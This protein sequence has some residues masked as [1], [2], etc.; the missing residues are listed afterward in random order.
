MTVQQ[1]TKICQNCKKEFI[2]AP[3]DFGFYKKID[4]PAP[5]F[6]PQCRFQ[7]R[8]AYRN[9]RKLHL[10]A[11]AKSGKQ[12]FSLYPSEGGA[13]VY[14]EPEWWADD[15][16]PM[17]YGRDYDFSK[18]FF[19]QFYELSQ[20]VPRYA[21]DVMNVVNSDYSGNAQ[22]FKNCY[23]LF[24]SNNVEDSAYGNAVDYS[25]TCFD[26]SHINKGERCYENFWLTNCHRTFFSVQC[27]DCINVWFS[28][29]CTGCTDCFGC[30]NL[31][32]KQFHI[33]NKPY[34]KEEYAQKIKAMKIDTWTGLEK[35]A[36]EAHDFWLGFPNKYMQGVKNVNANGEYVT[37]SKNVQEGYL[38]REGEDLKYVQYLQIP[39]NKDCYDITVWGESNTL[40]YEN[41]VCGA[42]TF[43]VKFCAEC[44]PDVRDME[45]SMFC[46]SSESLFGCAGLRKKKYCILNKQYSKDEFISLREKII[47]HMN[48][49][50]YVD[51]KGRVYRYGEFFPIELSAIPYNHSIVQEHFPL[52]E[53]AVKEQGWFWLNPEAKEYDITMEAS[54]LP[55]TSKEADKSILKEIIRCS[56]CKRA[57]RIIEPELAFLQEEGIP[58][59]R[60]CVDCRHAKRIAWRNKSLLYERACDCQGSSSQNA[61][62]KNEAN[63]F[64]GQGVCPNKFKSA[65]APDRPD[66]VYCEKCYIEEVA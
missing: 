54:T 14:S 16:D 9:D 42:G 29:N 58:L 63:H 46:K 47:D 65:Y 41:S 36:K 57:Y 26:N 55:E 35:A 56:E 34:S 45:Y 19:K 59:P 60:L 25:H 33:F 27:A 4:V 21:L 66:I 43:N 2:I 44:W 12:I 51:K 52:E 30:V 7:R 17:Q 64:H 23:L 50:P 1:E 39:F 22:Y 32:N 28:K 3:E 24:N 53:N 13:T 18:P 10:I 20:Q 8:A 31:R 62:Y 40:A 6:C 11:S 38:V 48:D 49:M 15:W 37:N 61:K 5:T